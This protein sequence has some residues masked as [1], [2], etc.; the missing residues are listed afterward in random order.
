[1]RN[2]Q[3][4]DVLPGKVLGKACHA[5]ENIFLLALRCKTVALKSKVYK[6]TCGWNC[7]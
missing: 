4:P 1:M 5:H 3:G 2:L 6:I 7:Q